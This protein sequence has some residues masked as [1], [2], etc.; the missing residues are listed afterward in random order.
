MS[1]GSVV[2]EEVGG[3]GNEFH[4]VGYV[5]RCGSV[6]FLLAVDVDAV[7]VIAYHEGHVMPLVGSYVACGKFGGVVYFP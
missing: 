6:D 4:H 3:I 1:V 2:D 7:A 5:A